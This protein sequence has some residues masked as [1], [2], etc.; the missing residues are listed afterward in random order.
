MKK[1]SRKLV[2][3]LNL[4][5]ECITCFAVCTQ[6]IYN[7]RIRVSNVMVFWSSLV[8]ISLKM[9]LFFSYTQQHYTAKREEF[10]LMIIENIPID[11]YWKWWKFLLE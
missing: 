1:K 4:R 10:L 5:C 9:Y 2:V 3:K 7:F 8:F 11:S 6:Y